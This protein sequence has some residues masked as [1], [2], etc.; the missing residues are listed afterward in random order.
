[1]RCGGAD[2]LRMRSRFAHD[3]G[4][5]LVELLVV[6]LILGILAAIAIPTFLGPSTANGAPS[7]SLI[8]TASL[9]ADAAAL[10]NG[11]VAINAK[12]LQTYEPTIATKKGG[13]PWVSAA[14]GTATGYTLTVT[15]ARTGNKFTISRSADGTVTRTCTI[16]TKTSQAGGCIV[17]KNKTKGVW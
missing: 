5:T 14:K 16:P 13:G 1:M 9:T 15:S 11:Y 8:H 10:E 2:Y 12:L 7:K 3:D 4:F 17:P 6:V